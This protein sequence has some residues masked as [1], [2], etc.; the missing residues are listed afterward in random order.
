MVSGPKKKKKPKPTLT[1]QEKLKPDPTTLTA[2]E[3]LKLLEILKPHYGV[4]KSKQTDDLSISTK[5]KVWDTITSKFND[6]ASI[7]HDKNTLINCF[8]NMMEKYKDKISAGMCLLYIF[9]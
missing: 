3:K 4:I 9:L 5:S 7:T 6:G 1:P 8:E 2:Q